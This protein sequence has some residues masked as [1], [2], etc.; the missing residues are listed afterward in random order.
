MPNEE[1]RGGRALRKWIE[2]DRGGRSY[3]GLA[4]KLGVTT[5]SLWEWRVG[6][7]TPDSRNRELIEAATGIAPSVWESAEEK[8]AM[9]EH[10]ERLASLRGE[11]AG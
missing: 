9:R 11:R 2:D 5:Q 3:K 6:L 1:S 4:E 8:R 10:E 7:S